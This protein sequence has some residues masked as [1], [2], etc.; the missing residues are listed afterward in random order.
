[1]P[2]KQNRKYKKYRTN[3]FNDNDHL[4]LQEYRKH[5]NEEI[6]KSKEKYLSDLGEKVA[7]KNTG[8]K[9]Y[10]KIVNKLLNKCKI[11]RIPPLLVAN[12]FIINCRKKATLFDNFFVSQCQPFENNSIQPPFNLLTPN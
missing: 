3:G 9:I 11:P 2:R 6:Q 4:V 8:Q 5:C 10:W 12:E 7:D 1:M